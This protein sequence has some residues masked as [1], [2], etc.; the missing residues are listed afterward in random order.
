[1]SNSTLTASII[2]KE[3]TMILDNELG[4]AKSVYRGHEREFS[5]SVNGYTVGSTVTIKRPTDFTV[6]DGATASIQ[7]VVE[8]STSITVNK[9]K[10]VDFQFSSLE[11]TLDIKELSERVIKPA[12][13]QLANQIDRDLM[14]LYSSVPNWVGTPGQTV[15][16]FSDFALAPQRLDTGAVPQD[17]RSAFLSPA[18]HWGLLGNQTGLYIQNAANGAYR[19]GSLGKIGGVDTFMSQNVPTHTVGVATGTPLVNGASQNVTYASVKATNAQD[20]VTDGWTN[21]TTG[22]LKAGDVITIAGVY[23]VNPVTKATLPHLKMFTVNAD[24]DS[25]ASTGPA[26]INISPAI[27]SSGAFQNVSA[28]PADN[29]AITVMGTGGTGYAQNLVFHKNAFALAMVPLVSPP[30]AVD[31]ARESYNGTSVRI[32]PYYDGT[33]DISKWRCDVLYGVKAIDP[34]LAVRLSGSA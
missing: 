9:Q 24:A 15:N 34:R 20:L 19:D 28:A 21:S 27:I 8:G 13:V 18:D 26:T 7:D 4:M 23:D 14:A 29:A 2:A 6:R 11:L 33:N 32:I 30:G 25:G 12:M 5:Q 3:A 17:M 1:M 10:G 22:I 16:S 31:V